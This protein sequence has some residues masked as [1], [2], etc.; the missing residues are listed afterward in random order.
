MDKRVL[1]WVLGLLASITYPPLSP[2]LWLI[3]LIDWHWLWWILKLTYGSRIGPYAVVKGNRLIIG[4]RAYLFYEAQ[5]LLDISTGH[6]KAL[7]ALSNML[8]RLSGSIAFYRLNGRLYIRLPEDSR[9]E[10]VL[11][12]FF[13]LRQVRPSQVVGIINRLSWIRI[14]WISLIG[15]L[16]KY[17]FNIPTVI[18]LLASI[19]MHS[20]RFSISLNQHPSI[21][22]TDSQ[23]AFT[24]LELADRLAMAMANAG[25]DYILVLE[26]YPG[27]KAIAVERY[28]HYR[29]LAVTRVR[30]RYE[31]LANQWRI[32]L[33]RLNAGEQAYKALIIGDLRIPSS[34][35]GRG[36]SHLDEP[37]V[38]ILT[39]DVQYIPI[40][41]G[42]A[43]ESGLARAVVEVG[44]DRFNNPV[45]LDLDAL[46]NA[47]GLIIGPS[48]RGKT[49]TVMSLILRMPQLSYLI[50]DPEGEYCRVLK[51][52]KCINARE[53]YI[54]YLA[55]ISEE[56][57]VK[58]NFIYDAFKASFGVEDDSILGLYNGEYPGLYRALE[59]LV[60]NSRY[61]RYWSMVRS[62]APR[63]LIGLE[64][65]FGG[66]I[67][68]DY[69]QLRQDDRIVSLLMQALI[70]EAF[71]AFL[72]THSEG[73]LVRQIIIA[74]EAY[75]ILASPAVW[76]LVRA[77]RKRGLAL[78]FATQSIRDAPPS[79]VQNLGW[80]I[81]LAGP[82][83][84]IDEVRPFFGLSQADYEWLRL[85]IP[86]RLLGG[87]WA[88]GILYAPPSP[89]HVYV[90]IEE[91]AY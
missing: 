31:E 71:N 5:P 81:I 87:E 58:A 47:H 86:P 51:D 85:D 68:I 41:Q 54:D 15:L 27:F 12:Q 19:I 36:L 50:L 8:N 42:Q 33:D 49:R 76:R 80:A 29:E 35:I 79:M 38:I 10:I 90:R 64:E 72:A 69:S 23:V 62:M 48:G 43:L 46:G 82:D 63:H 11:R 24:R 18:I 89:R 1:I 61:S 65:L 57:Y 67:I 59:W 37:N 21:G 52:W 17:P 91:K 6:E 88:M 14:V 70:G 2:I 39:N 75:L 73:E 3:S 4:N 44:I 60:G 55:P 22:I 16:V 26:P 40:F 66:R 53:A 74:D 45:T 30:G 25:K 13:T 9:D 20:K 84:Y 28:N 83:A 77:G 32:V 78:W 7:Y 56:A 34:R